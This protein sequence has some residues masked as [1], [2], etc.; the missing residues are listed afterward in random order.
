MKCDCRVTSLS[1]PVSLNGSRVWLFKRFSQ[2][3]VLEQHY[4]HHENDRN[5][6]DLNNI[7]LK[8]IQGEFHQFFVISNSYNTSGAVFKL[9]Y[10]DR[11]YCYWSTSCY[12][13]E[14]SYVF[15]DDGKKSSA[16]YL[17]LAVCTNPE[18]D[19]LM[20]NLQRAQSHTCSWGN[21]KMKQEITMK[22][23]TER[24]NTEFKHEEMLTMF[25]GLIDQRFSCDWYL[26]LRWEVTI[27]KQPQSKVIESISCSDL[28][29]SHCGTASLILDQLLICHKLS[30]LRVYF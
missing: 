2:L 9:L 17:Q 15:D 16:F 29:Q 20:R 21:F 6:G 25:K 30:V 5:H 3:M 26:R 12:K 18:Q 4:Q 27:S 11:M 10:F 28:F 24:R 7:T 23:W 1:R 19:T 13:H 22:R 14:C 8:N